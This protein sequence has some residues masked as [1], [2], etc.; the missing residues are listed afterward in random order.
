MCKVWY[1]EEHKTQDAALEEWGVHQG[2]WLWRQVESV[3]WASVPKVLW[4]PMKL[5]RAQERGAYGREDVGVRVCAPKCRR[6]ACPGA[7]R[8]RRN[9][10]Q[11]KR[12]LQSVEECRQGQGMG[13]R[14]LVS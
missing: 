10:G 6:K 14:S 9:M 2:R 12:A 3:S 13:E 1:L 5:P 8:T 11:D 4:E 7:C